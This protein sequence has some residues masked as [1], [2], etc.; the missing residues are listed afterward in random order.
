LSRQLVKLQDLAEV[1]ILRM[2]CRAAMR[3]FQCAC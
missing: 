1:H 3:P 2:N